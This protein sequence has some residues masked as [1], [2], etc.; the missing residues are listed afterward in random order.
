MVINSLYYKACDFAAQLY[1][2]APTDLVHDTFVDWYDKKGENIF[3][4]PEQIVL[5]MIRKT[6]H[7]KRYHDKS[8]TRFTDKLKQTLVTPEDE[9][10]EREMGLVFLTYKE[11]SDHIEAYEQTHF[12]YPRLEN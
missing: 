8:L 5:L 10:I 11:I 2:A 12:K 1:P 6:F 9:L 4:E 3:D 7:T